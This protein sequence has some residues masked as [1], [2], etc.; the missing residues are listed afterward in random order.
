[1]PARTTDN[2]GRKAVFRMQKALCML[3]LLF[4]N[5][6]QT[7]QG[8]LEA[9]L[10]PPDIRFPYTFGRPVSVSG[11]RMLVGMIR[12]SMNQFPGEP[13]VTGTICVFE[14][15]DGGW[16]QR[17][18]L[19][20]KEPKR[21][22]FGL[23]TALSGKVAI[24]GDPGAN[25]YGNSAGAAYIFEKTGPTSWTHILDL[26]PEDLSSRM[27]FGAAVAISGS[28]AA[29]GAPLGD[30][31]TTTG[32]VYVY[33]RK[34]N[35][36][37]LSAKLT[38]QE[39]PV[40]HVGWVVSTDGV[41]IVAGTSVISRG[42]KPV[43]VFQ[44]LGEVWTRVAKLTVSDGGRFGESVAVSGDVIVAGDT[45]TREDGELRFTGAA[46]VFEW[47]GRAWQQVAKLT[48]EI[49][50]PYT[51]LGYAVATDGISIVVGAYS[52]RHDSVNDVGAVY[53]FRKNKGA[54]E[55]TSKLHPLRGARGD[56][57]GTALSLDTGTLVVGAPYAD[58]TLIRDAGLA[59]VYDLANLPGIHDL[60]E[61]FYATVLGR[62]PEAGAVDAWEHS[63]FDVAVGLGID[64]RF[65][66]R[67]MGRLFFL[68]EEY[69]GR[70]RNDAEFIVDC[71]RGFLLR[72][73]SPS[74]VAKWVNDVNK[75]GKVRWN[76]AQV[77]TAFAESEEF[78][79]LIEAL[80][81]NRGG[82]PTRNFVTTMYIGFFD[83]LPDVDGMLAWA[84]TANAAENKKQMAR[85]MAWLFLDSEEGRALGAHQPWPGG[86]LVPRFP[87]AFSRRSRD[88]LLGCRV[89]RRAPDPRKPDRS[90]RRIRRVRSDPQRVLRKRV[91][92]RD[93]RRRSLASF[94]VGAAP[95][96]TRARE[97]APGPPFPQV[98]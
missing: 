14:K 2:R 53:I 76:R 42:E 71:Y 74:E 6:A 94:C 82:D 88:R 97:A 43:Y 20:A 57:Y 90:L 11:N 63:H 37:E 18:T 56:S 46:Y 80:F 78:A 69:A 85:E 50:L 72:K 91:T 35:A 66:T 28:V 34:E 31:E 62:E 49:A 65:M 58:S 16:A 95:G 81:P 33:E 41:T 12:T 64:V 4:W 3:G 40:E 98:P 55:Q 89:G 27:A 67:E 5:L 83:R 73:P 22:S 79:G 10:A 68:S 7:A 84:N 59:Y 54:W 92:G 24:I 38:G 87:G 17:A 48:D 21:K 29:V 61:L 77:M 93:T 60:V 19:T 30:F 8:T 51:N 45:Y 96:I 44:K 23:S 75:H 70:A 9:I 1:M 36:W 47:D 39:D 32:K 86:A 52:T 25:D 26:T 15:L 13:V